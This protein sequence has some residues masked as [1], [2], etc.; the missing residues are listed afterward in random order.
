MGNRTPLS[1][2]W[3]RKEIYRDARFF[4]GALQLHNLEIARSI[5]GY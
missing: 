4:Q 5:L 2:G 3:K 1:D